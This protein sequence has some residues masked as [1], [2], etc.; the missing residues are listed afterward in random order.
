MSG[1]IAVTGA[2]GFVGGA[3][4]RRLCATGADVRV[5]GRRTAARAADLV[6]AG[7]EA[8]DFDL[9]DEDSWKQVAE[10]MDVIIHAAAWV[11]EADV[12]MAEPLN[13]TAVEAMVRAAATAGVR[14]I[15]HISTVAVYDLLAHEV[16]TEDIAPDLDQP[17]PYGATKARGEA[18]GLALSR[19]H[20]VEFVSIR[21]A[22]VYGPG[23]RPWTLGMLKLVSSGTPCVFG[24]GDGLCYLLFID[25]LVDAII[26]ACAAPE[27]NGQCIHLADSSLTWNDFLGRYGAMCGRTPRAIPMPAARALAWLAETFPLGLP[28]DRRRLA[29]TQHRAR[30]DTTRASEL[31]GWSPAIDIDEGMALTEAWLRELGKL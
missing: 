20:G 28:L 2:T 24:R 17:D 16:F 25:N 10:G 3:V 9:L 14:R 15:V 26:A 1:R 8:V 22:M 31:L 12:S 19:Q 23:S 6:E 30:F 21:P 13:V 7:A 18:R 5:A 29:I 27:V 4:A 11:D